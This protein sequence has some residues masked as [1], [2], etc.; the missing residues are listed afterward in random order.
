[1]LEGFKI[2]VLANEGYVLNWLWYV[3]GDN[4]GPV[5]LN[6]YFTKEKGFLKTQAVILDLLT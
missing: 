4:R 2:W 5:N 1:M 3:R 6:E